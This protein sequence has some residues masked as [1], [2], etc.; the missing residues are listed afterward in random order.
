MKIIDYYR[1]G[2]AGP[3]RNT[4][5]TSVGEKLRE[6]IL[7]G[8]LPP[9]SRISLREAGEKYG[10]S[11]SPLREALSRL[12]T[13]GLVIVE[14][15][16]GFRVAPVSV[17]NCSELIRLRMELEPLALG[18]SIRKGND[19]WEGSVAAAFHRLSKAEKKGLTGGATQT[20][21]E[22]LNRHF[23]SAL[24]SASEMPL[25]IEM[26]GK[27]SDLYDRYRRLFLIKQGPDLAAVGEHEAI[28]KATVARDAAKACQLLRRHI[29]RSGNNVLPIVIKAQETQKSRAPKERRKRKPTS[30]L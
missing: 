26:C 8:S 11:L 14:D 6:A 24:I 29:E 9:G 2:K 15:L 27:L 20:E 17:G 10:T 19:E 18:E 1:D 13:D 22:Q 12:S 3:K 23:H 21:W 7:D 30:T 28:F 25:L 16:R 5:A 4:L